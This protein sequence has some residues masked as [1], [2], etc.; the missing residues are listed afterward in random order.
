MASNCFY[1][2]LKSSKL[3]LNLLWY[4]AMPLFFYKLPKPVRQNILSIGK[5]DLYGFFKLLF[6]KEKSNDLIYETLLCP[7]ILAIENVWD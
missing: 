4:T 1:F 3:P 2:D 5:S 6:F 7:Y